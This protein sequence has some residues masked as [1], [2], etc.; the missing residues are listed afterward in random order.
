VTVVAREPDHGVQLTPEEEARL[1][2]AMA[3]ADR[4]DTIPAEELFARLGRAAER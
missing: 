1:L 4:G 2:E 3:E